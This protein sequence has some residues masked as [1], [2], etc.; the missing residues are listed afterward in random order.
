MKKK[1]PK[2]ISFLELI[3]KY[4][5]LIEE[6]MP[7]QYFVIDIG[8]QENQ[9]E[10]LGKFKTIV[11]NVKY[12][13]FQKEEEKIANDLFHLQSM[14]NANICL[15]EMWVSLKKN[16]H[17]EAWNR[18]IDVY[19]YVSIAIRAG[20]NH[21]GID[22][23]I[24]KVENI[25]KVIFPGFN[26][27]ISIGAIISGGK[28]TICLQ[29]I[30]DCDHIEGMIYWGRLCLRVEAIIQGDH[31]ALVDHPKDRRCLIRE[32]LGDDG[33]YID[34]MTKKRL[35]RAEEKDIQSEGLK[36]SITLLKTTILDIY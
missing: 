20:D 32:V 36:A 31:V 13:A 33:Y 16:N 8:L 24:A 17:R 1:K 11:V 10:I 12:Q 27:F 18:L 21:F 19:E 34:Y 5:K 3:E 6:T 4:N 2:K 26:K 9:I 25:E 15:L 23:F 7:L 29:P 28:C 22:E 14:L 35:H 30:D